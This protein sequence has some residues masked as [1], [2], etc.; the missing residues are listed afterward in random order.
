M[1]QELVLL[2][3]RAEAA[4]YAAVQA[5]R[6]LYDL[7]GHEASVNSA[8][9]SPDGTKVVTASE[10]GTA[11]IWSVVDGKELTVLRGHKY[12]V[13]SAAFSPDGTKVVT[14]SI[15]ASIF[16]T[17]ESQEEESAPARVWDAATGGELAQLR[18]GIGGVISAQFSPDG[19]KVLTASFD[20]LARVWSVAD[21][22]QLT[23][24]SGHKGPV[25]SAF[26][27]G[28]RRGVRLRVQLER[29]RH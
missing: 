1:N 28:D 25:I 18:A 11:R 3:S 29:Q 19:T 2:L 23:V 5:N 13:N 26:R 10:D 12:E 20:G 27:R 24:L 8:A 17:R 15:T 4:L 21:G 6:E 16:R 9:F 14:A 22:T 7:V